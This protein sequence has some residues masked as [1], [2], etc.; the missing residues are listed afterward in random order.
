MKRLLI[1]G[2]FLFGTL[3]GEAYRKL[4]P[5]NSSFKKWSNSGQMLLKA[6]RQ[7]KHN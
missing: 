4:N 2:I 7:I 5:E 6:P 1:S 3:F